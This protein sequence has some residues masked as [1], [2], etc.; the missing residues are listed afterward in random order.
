MWWKPVYQSFGVLSD[1]GA[2]RWGGFGHRGWWLVGAGAVSVSAVVVLAGLLWFLAREGREFSDQWASIF[3]LPLAWLAATAAVVVW[4]VRQ[5]RWADGPDAAVVRLRRAVDRLWR[6]VATRQLHLPRPLRLRWRPTSRPGVQV[7]MAACVGGSVEGV[8]GALLSCDDIR[9]PAV[10]LVE[11]MRDPA[12]RQLVVLGEPGAGKTTLA[13]LYVLAA[14][15]TAG[16]D[17]PVPIPLPVA[18]W[19]PAD[20]GVEDWIVQRIYQD[21]PQLNAAQVRE[22]V[23]RR[24]VIAVL[25]GLD[26]MPEV[27]RGAALTQLEVAAGAGLR[28]VLTCRSEEFARATAAVGVLP[29]AVVVDIEPV[30]VADAV[31]YLTE[32]EAVGSRR[33][34]PVTASMTGNRQGPLASA[35]STPLMIALARQ[36]YQRPAANPGELTT[37]ATAEAIQR[38]LLDRFLPS[39]YGSEHA[40][41]KAGRWLALLI[42]RLPAH[43]GDPNLEWWRLPR[44]VPRPMIVALVTATATLLGAFLGPVLALIGKASSFLPYSGEFSTDLLR[45]FGLA[46]LAKGGAAVGFLIGLIA[47]LHAAR[48][49]HGPEPAP[50]RLAWLRAMVVGFVDIWTATPI[51]SAVGAAILLTASALVEPSV[52]TVNIVIADAIRDPATLQSLWFEILLL[53][54][55]FDVAMVFTYRLGAGGVGTPHRSTLRLRGL[56][57]RLLA[58]LGIGLLIGLPWTVLGVVVFGLKLQSGLVGAV[59]VA[60]F[61][62]IPLGL[63][64]WLRS[65]ATQQDSAS[66]SSVLRRDRTALLITVVGVALI[67]AALTALVA[68]LAMG[69]TFADFGLFMGAIVAV[70][71]LFGSGSAWLSYSTARLWLALTGRLPWRLMR[72]LR[73]AHR[74]GVLRQAGAAYQVRHDLVRTHLAHRWT[75]DPHG[76]PRPSAGPPANPIVLTL[77]PRVRRSPRQP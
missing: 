72:F 77:W 9:S 58:G 71:I 19:D 44:A 46:G 3:A 49:G 67:T 68:V 29:Q 1:T 60:G 63:A 50:R 74:N 56:P 6:E 41:G 20:V 35:L 26:E 76:S 23:S 13:L 69:P 33:W 14:A 27:A 12:V 18:G 34:A 16:E 37:L 62:G 54:V 22:L 47:G 55:V 21:Y 65:P 70:L 53:A 4:M 48:A 64:R 61:V 25:D 40:A 28:M 5:A 30:D 52:I 51:W 73:A 24:K 11:A 15:D 43:P 17:D 66:P 32:R 59:L 10:E 42:R 57:L 8:Q 2:V 36:V 38:R 7:D 75:P 45:V 39:V 31:T